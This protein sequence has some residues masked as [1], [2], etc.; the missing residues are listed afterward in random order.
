[1]AAETPAAESRT[2][3]R[4][5][6]A[7]ADLAEATWGLEVARWGRAAGSGVSGTDAP[8]ATA[9]PASTAS[10][11]MAAA[12]SAPNPASA[13]PRQIEDLGSAST[14][15]GRSSSTEISSA[16]KGIRDEPPISNT[17]LKSPGSTLIPRRLRSSAFTVSR[18]GAS[19]RASNSE[20]T[21]RSVRWVPGS[22]TAILASLSMDRASLASRHSR[23]NLDNAALLSGASGSS[24]SKASSRWPIT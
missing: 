1:M 24:P 12:F 10:A 3:E 4:G 23:R 21:S 22:A 5:A 2:R 9:T 15:I 11:S 16:T 17:A 20:R 8:A 18:M 6:W 13:A 19:I 14:A 7:A